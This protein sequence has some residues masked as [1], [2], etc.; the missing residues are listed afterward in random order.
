MA[1]TIHLDFTEDGLEGQWADVVNV[2]LKSPRQFAH[3][4]RVASEEGGKSL[5]ALAVASWHVKDPE[6]DEPLPAPDADELDLTAI[7]L[8]VQKRIADSIQDQFAAVLPKASAS[9]KS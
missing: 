4:S 9:G 5:V 8:I 7:P 3:L 2:G 6:T 1:K